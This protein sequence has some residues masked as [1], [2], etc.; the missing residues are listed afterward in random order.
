MEKGLQYVLCDGSIFFSHCEG[1][2]KVSLKSAESSNILQMINHPCFL[3]ALG[4]EVLF[5]NQM[6]SSVWRITECGKVEIFA[7]V[8]NE[9]GEEGSVDGKVKNCRFR[10]PIGICTESDNVIYITDAQTNSIKICTTVTECA[11]FLASIGKLYDA[12]SVHSTG[13]GYTIRSADEAL[14]LVRDCKELLDSNSEDIRM[15][16]GSTHFEWTTRPCCR[17]DGSFCRND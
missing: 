2:S 12:F 9:E 10:Q 8:E 17:K 5:T 16:T 14:A 15:S 3:T 7:G 4:S 6:K 11:N 1:I 13:K